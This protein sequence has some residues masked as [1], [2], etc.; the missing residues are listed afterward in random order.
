MPQPHSP[1]KQE[2][3]WINVLCNV[4]VPALILAKLS[5]EDRLG[6]E[7]GLVAALTFPLAY[8]ITDLIRRGKYNFLSILGFVSVLLTGG[9]GLL[10][11]DGIWFAVK[12]AAVPLLIGAAILVSTRTRFPLV[13]SLLYNDK[14]IETERVRQ[15]LEKRANQPAFDRLLG[16]AT[17]LLSGSFFLSAALNFGLARAFLTSPSGTPEFNVQLGKMTAW[18][19]PIIVIPSMLV[20]LAA[21]WLLVAG[22]RRLTGLPLEEIFRAPPEKQPLPQRKFD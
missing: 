18:S 1:E 19:W 20:T 14:L 10:K 22:V 8:G 11:V 5:S 9:L 16:R 7:F 15:A 12:E 21:L 2:N 4:A 6:P 13:R 17:L 3:L